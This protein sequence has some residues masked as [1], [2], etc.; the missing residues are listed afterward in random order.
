MLRIV[1]NSSKH[2]VAASSIF[3][4]FFTMLSTID[5]S[6]TKLYSFFIVFMVKKSCRLCFQTVNDTKNNFIRFKYRVV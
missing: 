3:N 1:S 5:C 6:K 2:F 4:I